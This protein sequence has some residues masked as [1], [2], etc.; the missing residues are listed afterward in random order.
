[1]VKKNKEI[2]KVRELWGYNEFQGDEYIPA[3]CD[4]FRVLEINNDWFEYWDDVN[5][6][7]YSFMSKYFDGCRSEVFLLRL[8]VLNDFCNQYGYELRY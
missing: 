2:I 7:G 5:T 6:L 1:M 3:L 4:S 8:L